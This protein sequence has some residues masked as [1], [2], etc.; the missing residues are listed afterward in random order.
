MAIVNFKKLKE[1]AE[2]SKETH[3]I[4]LGKYVDKKLEGIIIPIKVKSIEEC[5]DF[6]NKFKLKKE[7]LTI[8]YKPFTRMPKDFRQMYMESD[9]Y[10]RGK[11]ENT[12]FQVLEVSKDETTIEKKKYRQRLFNILVH[13]DM[14]YKTD[15]GVSLWEDASIPKD[16]YDA[17]VD[18]F[19]DIIKYEIHLDKLDL[20]I[21]KIKSGIINEDELTSS[22]AMMDLKHYLDTNFDTEEDKLQ[23][24][25]DIV[26]TATELNKADGTEAKNET[27]EEVVE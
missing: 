16:D 17:L 7:K 19:S 10:Q 5:I 11:T 26:N 9:D 6:K 23:A 12:Y 25:K 15:E 3:L 1:V 21:D 14:E 20:V 13:F 27:V 24:F 8:K 4:D 2:K 18:I 22:I